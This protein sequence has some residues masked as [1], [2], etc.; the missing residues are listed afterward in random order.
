MGG[1]PERG[2]HGVGHPK[3][4]QVLHRLL[5]QVVID[6]IDLVLAPQGEQRL[7]Q[8]VGGGQILA[9]RLFDDDPLPP[10]QPRE[11]GGGELLIDHGE[12][13]GRD[14]QVEERVVGGSGA[15]RHLRHQLPQPRISFGVADLARCV[16]QPRLEPLPSLL[17]EGPTCVEAGDLLPLLAA[18]GLGGHVVAGHAD[19]GEVVGQ[20][21][22]TCQV[23]EC[24]HEQPLGQVA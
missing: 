20:E 2:E 10:R 23:V 19:D 1:V 9:E 14:R 13:I 6:A 17:I 11:A 15:G 18:E 3:R 22:V 8:T 21:S 24:R 7:V 16:M 4:E 5:A 12:K